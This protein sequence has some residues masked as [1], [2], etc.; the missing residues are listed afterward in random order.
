MRTK[1]LTEYAA[2]AVLLVSGAAFR[3]DRAAAADPACNRVCLNG[4]VDQ[5]LAALATRD[6]SRLPVTGNIRFTEDS[7]PLKLGDGLWQTVTGVG[8]YRIYCDESE[9]GEVGSIDVIE[10]NKL[11]AILMLRLKVVDHKISEVETILVRSHGEANEE[12]RAHT[13]KLA[14]PDPSFQQDVP[15]Q[16]RPSRQ[17]MIATASKYFNG[18]VQDNGKMIPYD[19]TGYRILNGTL[20]CNDTSAASLPPTE[21]SRFFSMTCP[22][23]IATG[24]YKYIHSISP[25]RF[26]VVDREKG[27]VLALIRFNHPGNVLTEEIEGQGTVDMT[28]NAWAQHPTSALMAELF[29]LE[30]GRIH[31][32]W[33]VYTKVPYKNPVGWDGE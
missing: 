29:K 30:N 2:I 32:I 11:P 16:G 19:D 1:F 8:T 5:Y 14:M 28:K 9:A 20:D 27:L 21:N 17:E 23:Q 12:E 7:A 24:K 33:G 26:P 3:P 4:F 10:E 31:I 25:R 15:A 13:E 22:A 18:I 6:P